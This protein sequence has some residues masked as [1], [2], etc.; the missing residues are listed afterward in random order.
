MIKRIFQDLD[1]CILHTLV[2]TI[3]TQ[4]Y[5]EFTLGE[6]KHTYRSIIRPCAKKLF[7][8]Y[9][10]IVGKENVYILTTATRDYAEALN[11]LGEFGL[12]ADHIL[13]REDIAKYSHKSAWSTDSTTIEHPLADKD[14]I[15]IDNLQ[16]KYNMSKLLFLGIDVDNYYQTSEY[17]GVSFCDDPK[18]ANFLKDI[19]KFINK[20]RNSVATDTK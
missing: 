9:N 6:D 12:D 17:Y 14:N 20:R 16:W 7:A 18:E 19:K 3:P 2:N 15:L 1:E 4:D 11:R 10:K 8:Y 5:V 13:T